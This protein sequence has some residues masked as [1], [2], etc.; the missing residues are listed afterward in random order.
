MNLEKKKLLAAR[1]LGVGKNRILFNTARLSE[2][3]DSITKQD[4][5]DLVLSKAIVI[6]SIKGRKKIKKKSRRRAGSVRK[7]I[8]GGKQEYVKRI[9]RLRSYLKELRNQNKLSDES[10]WKLRK[11]IKAGIHRT[12]H[13]L[14]ERISQ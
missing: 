4:I 3:K 7:K 13:H 11:E 9:R 12:K 10:Y 2:I 6:K 5:R 14:K 1:T 8:K